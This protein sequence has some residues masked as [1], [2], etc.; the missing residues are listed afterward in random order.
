MGRERPGP[1]LRGFTS[2]L[3]TDQGLKTQQQLFSLVLSRSF[4]K[5][6]CKGFWTYTL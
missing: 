5:E 4:G 1:C 2:Q 6:S 3:G